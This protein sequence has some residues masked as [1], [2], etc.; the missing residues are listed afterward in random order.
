MDAFNTIHTYT[1]VFDFNLLPLWFVIKILIKQRFYCDSTCIRIVNFLIYHSFPPCGGA[2]P[3][4]RPNP[5]IA[6]NRRMA[7]FT[8]SVES[9]HPSGATTVI[10]GSTG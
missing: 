6:T 1:Q 10:L 4:S 8:S 9:V 5:A 7:A 3:G 2:C